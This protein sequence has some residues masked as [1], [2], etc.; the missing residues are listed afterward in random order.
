MLPFA[1]TVLRFL[2]AI[3][4][5]W[6]D[7]TFRAGLSVAILILISGTTFYRTVEGW[8]WTDSLYF[9]VTTMSTVGLG[10]LSPVTQIGK[11]FTVFYIFAGV[12][13]FVAL[14]AQFARALVL[15]P[16]AGNPPGKDG[17]GTG[18]SR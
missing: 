9:S 16:K 7:E 12:G 13:V 6:Q 11:I 8:S 15:D 4:R 10:D 5:S 14:F 2:K 17:A 1:L 18:Q 3:Y